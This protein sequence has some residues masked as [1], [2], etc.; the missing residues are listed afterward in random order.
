MVA[1][2]RVCSGAALLFPLPSIF[3]HGK[4]GQSK[5]NRFPLHSLDKK[6]YPNLEAPSSNMCN[7]VPMY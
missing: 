3:V 6:P 5:A 7:S 2:V 1:S 4:L